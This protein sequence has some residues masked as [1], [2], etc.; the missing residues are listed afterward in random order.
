MY[1]QGLTQEE[2]EKRLTELGKNELTPPP[3]TPEYV[4]F[5]KTLVGGFALLLW[6][7]AVLCFIAYA[8]QR[9]EYM[10]QDVPQDNVSSI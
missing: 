9:E 7:G 3:V 2:A 10:G 5:L 6:A 4:K 8:I 1:C